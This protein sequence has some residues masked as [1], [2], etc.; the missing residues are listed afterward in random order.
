M[1]KN[2]EL[3]FNLG[4][5]SDWTKVEKIYIDAFPED[6][7]QTCETIKNRLESNQIKLFV[8]QFNQTI[9]G[10]ALVW[11]ISLLTT[12]YIEYLAISKEY[13]SNGIGE[14]ILSSIKQSIGKEK[15]IVEMEDPAIDLTDIDKIRRFKFYQKNNFELI[16]NITYT[17][18]ALNSENAAISMFLLCY[19]KEKQLF[20]KHFLTNFVEFLY[21]TVYQKEKNNFYLS[22]IL[23]SL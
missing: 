14:F 19:S 18:P 17:M 10:F 13:R 4:D 1:I 6:E 21:L 15:L 7:R 11:E 22:K 5:I 16:K 3:T 12:H 9:V 23:K 8:V 2:G 20:S